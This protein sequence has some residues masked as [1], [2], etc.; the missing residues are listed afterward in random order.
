M[1]DPGFESSQ[2]L[3]PFNFFRSLLERHMALT[4]AKGVKHHLFTDCNVNI[5]FV[6]E[7]IRKGVKIMKLPILYVV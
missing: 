7:R 5:M 1:H 3:F 6:H 4:I 2:A